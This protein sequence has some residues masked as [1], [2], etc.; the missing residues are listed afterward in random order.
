MKRLIP[1]VIVLL[2]V[3][4]VCAAQP[5]PPAPSHWFNDE[6]GVV[7]A[8]AARR[9]DDELQ[10]F[11][12]QTSNQF[13]VVIYPKLPDGAAMEEYTVRLA[14]AWK[15]GR[16][17]RRN[18]V[19]LFVFLR[20]HKMRIEVGYGLE[21]ALPDATAYHIITGEIAPHFRQ[22]DYEGGLQA[23]IHAIEA[24]TRGEYHGNSR[25]VG[26]HNDGS[27][28]SWAVLIIIIVMFLILQA[29]LRSM[30]PGGVYTRTGFSTRGGGFGG[31]GGG[32]GFSGGGGGFGGGGASGGW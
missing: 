17:D 10:Q 31:W 3:A 11:E 21:G 18:G 23:G 26:E 16:A 7:S 22:K 8:D 12:K 5:I 15:I 19:V 14:Q 32:G 20:D 29:I 4:A 30:N 9:F 24:A 6:A 27:T 25:T 13:I 28:T 2:G 1:I